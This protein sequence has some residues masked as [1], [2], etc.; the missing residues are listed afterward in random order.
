MFASHNNDG[1]DR[2]ELNRNEG[3]WVSVNRPHG[4]TRDQITHYG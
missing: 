2:G 4:Y 3:P 1:A